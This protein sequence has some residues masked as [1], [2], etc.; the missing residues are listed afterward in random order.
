MFKERSQ[1]LHSRNLPTDV[2]VY[3]LGW[4]DVL[5]VP[6]IARVSRSF[7]A[8]VERRQRETT[9]LNQALG[10]A[11]KWVLAMQRRPIVERWAVRL[12][13]LT[14]YQECVQV[15]GAW[16]GCLYLTGHAL[17]LTSLDLSLVNNITSQSEYLSVCIPRLVRLRLPTH[18]PLSS[19]FAEPL[20][21]L[22]TSLHELTCPATTARRQGG[23]ISARQV[24]QSC[25]GLHRLCIE[26][27]AGYSHP[28]VAMDDWLWLAVD[29]PWREL[30]E[31]TLKYGPWSAN[32]RVVQ[33]IRA[34]LKTLERVEVRD[35][36]LGMHLCITPLVSHLTL[37][38][39]V[40]LPDMLAVCP[41]TTERLE[42][43]AVL[44][45]HFDTVGVEAALDALPHLVELHAHAAWLS[46][47]FTC[48][49]L[50]D[51]HPWTSRIRRVTLHITAS[52][53]ERFGSLH[54]LHHL[55]RLQ[56]TGH[57][58]NP[59]LWRNDDFEL[60]WPA[61]L[62]ELCLDDTMALDADLE[63]FQETLQEMKSLHRIE[64]RWCGVLCAT[65]DRITQQV[66]RFSLQCPQ[67]I[68]QRITAICQFDK[69]T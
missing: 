2:M 4:V 19:G 45:T 11:Q 16:E 60:Y 62:V 39:S 33:P 12:Q 14:L 36:R 40:Y 55:E 28:D 6:C 68:Q 58:C 56:L 32:N 35:D 5:E 49:D 7:R 27:P 43:F 48:C 41:P 8:A 22:G 29:G 54:H 13:S 63:P 57:V 31:L 64:Y 61:T 66:Q 51:S 59:A 46:D 21:R 30:K 69:E 25:R 10:S 53:H 18:M 38:R 47:V 44:E 9:E 37:P 65:I 42:L 34:L 50:V 1:C 17:C 67:T 26:W 23:L 15:N 24:V 3:V 52:L 20:A